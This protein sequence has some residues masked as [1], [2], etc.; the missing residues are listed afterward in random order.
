MSGS[1]SH[2][3]TGNSGWQVIDEALDGVRR[4]AFNLNNPDDFH[5]LLTRQLAPIGV[6]G[7]SLWQLDAGRWN[8]S[9]RGGESIPPTDSAEPNRAERVPAK[10]AFAERALAEKAL[11]AAAW[12]A[13]AA[14]LTAGLE[15]RTLAVAAPFGKGDLVGGVFVA[16]RDQPDS[17]AATQGFA[18]L[19][20][21]LA[22]EIRLFALRRAL[23]EARQA[24]ARQNRLDPLLVQLHEHLS[25]EAATQ[26]LV[27]EARIV[28]DCDRVAVSL[29]ARRRQRLAAIS[30]SEQPHRQSAVVERLEPLCSAV[31]AIGEPLW[32]GGR[33]SG[34]TAAE[35][36]PPEL[37]TLWEAYREVSPGQALVIVPLRLPKSS[38]VS[39]AAASESQAAAALDSNSSGSTVFATLVCERIERSF[40]SAVADLLRQLEPHAA[41]ALANARMMSRVPLG[42]FWLRWDRSGGR[43]VWRRGAVVAA[44]FALMVAA[45]LLIPS[46]LE[47]RASGELRS[48]ARRE[49]FAPA[50]GVVEE[51]RVDHGQL[52][53]ANALLLVVHAPELDQEWQEARSVVDGL[54]RQ[55]ASVQ[56]Q[57]LQARS[58]DVASRQ[59]AAALAAEEE[60]LQTQRKSQ[61]ERLAMLERRRKSL[62]VRSPIAGRIV[63]WGLRDRLAGRPLRQGDA[64]LTVAGDG[65]PFELELQVPER[66]A[67][68]VLASAAGPA[69]GQQVAW[70]LVSRPEATRRGT[71]CELARR[72]DHD[73]WGGAFLRVRV[74]L[75]D[76]PGNGAAPREIGE[77]V[78]AKIACGRVSLAEAWFFELIDTT[79]RWWWL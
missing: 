25:L 65:G 49:V 63:S 67:G 72:F 32:L 28:L 35:E 15:A 29:A 70:T 77:L 14:R 73:D 36:L 60:Q 39:A 22:E 20:E 57:R 31:A 58:G 66:V 41:A 56:S 68:R 11:V 55:L 59:R 69:G 38:D 71:V 5:G 26:Q 24:G 4:A 51:L 40:D 45:L 10:R 17:G 54:Q 34:G 79:R 74:T 8:R 44:A 48:V 12:E 78:A 42:R 13:N 62:R 53:A 19:A 46:E 61:A 75:E 37:S 1:S 18:R 16:W 50:D 7:W 27:N 9:A 2:S 64:L 30:G 43:S 23:F 21:A 6:I 52:V 33:P 47:V 3:P 76:S